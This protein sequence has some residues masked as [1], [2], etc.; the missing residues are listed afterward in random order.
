MPYLAEDRFV[1]FVKKA[2]VGADEIQ[3]VLWCDVIT[4]SQFV[5]ELLAEDSHRLVDHDDMADD[6]LTLV[7]GNQWILTKQVHLM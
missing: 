1:F 7:V 5:L 6:Q 2:Q 3:I 4:P